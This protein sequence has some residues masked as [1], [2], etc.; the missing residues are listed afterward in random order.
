MPKAASSA[1]GRSYVGAHVIPQVE[2]VVAHV[3]PQVAAHVIPHRE[4]ERG[5]AGV[6][7]AVRMLLPS[8]QADGEPDGE[9]KFQRGRRDRD[10]DPLACGPVA[11]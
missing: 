10:L 5:V 2:A 11:E 3:I 6:V 7:L 1:A 8:E 4:R 9:E